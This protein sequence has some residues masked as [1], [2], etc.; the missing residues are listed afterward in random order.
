MKI[1]LKIHFLG[2]QNNYDIYKYLNASDLAVFPQSQSVLWQQAIS[3]ELPLIVGVLPGSDVDYLNKYNNIMIL[4]K[5]N[6][7]S[8]NIAHNI[9]LLVNNKSRLVEMKIGAKKITDELLNWNNL[10]L[11][12][13]NF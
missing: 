8:D 12:T 2:W 13:L 7:T 1:N 10:I 11:K 4:D 5:H 3:M 6:I 9:K